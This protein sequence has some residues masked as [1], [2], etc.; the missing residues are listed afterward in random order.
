MTTK[1]RYIF[2]L[3]VISWRCPWTTIGDQ[4]KCII[5]LQG[6]TVSQMTSWT[7]VCVTWS[8]TS[9]G[10]RAWFTTWAR[11]L[12]TKFN[13]C[14]HSNVHS[15]WCPLWWRWRHWDRR[16]HLRYVSPSPRH[17]HPLWNPKNLSGEGPPTSLQHRTEVYRCLQSALLPYTH[18]IHFTRPTWSIQLRYVTMR[19]LGAVGEW[20]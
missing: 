16:R 2:S 19:T 6:E 4:I 15:L 10:D 8:V 17:A 20:S 5:A 1:E 14:V 11:D 13:H 12:V 9:R 18:S 7:A 3:Y